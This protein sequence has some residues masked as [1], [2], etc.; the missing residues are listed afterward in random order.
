MGR[1]KAQLEAREDRRRKANAVI[2]AM[3]AH[4]RRFFYSERTGR[5]AH[6]IFDERGRLRFI[7]DYTGTAIHVNAK[8][9]RHGFTHGGTCRSIVVMLAE[10]ITHNRPVRRGHFGPWAAWRDEDVWGYGT[11]AMNKVR[12]DIEA[13]GVYDS[14][15]VSA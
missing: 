10:Y 6:F 12:S 2:W 14:E 7:D 3:S 13:S 1:T 5:T 8:Y 9:W 11:E 15:A 4:G